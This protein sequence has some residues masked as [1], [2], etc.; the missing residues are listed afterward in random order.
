M[1]TFSVSMTVWLETTYTGSLPVTACH[2]AA[3]ASSAPSLT[4]VK[5][6]KGMF[7]CF[8]TCAACTPTQSVSPVCTETMRTR[9]AWFGSRS[10]SG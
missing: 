6:E 4:L 8:C 1:G 3:T 7:T 10:R 2:A 9:R 5:S